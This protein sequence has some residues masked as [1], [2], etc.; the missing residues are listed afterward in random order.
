VG[1]LC[2]ARGRDALAHQLGQSMDGS[3]WLLRPDQHVMAAGGPQALAPATLAAWVSDALRPAGADGIDS[4]PEA[5]G[6]A[7]ANGDARHA[8]IPATA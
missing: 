2:D 4:Q 6:L 7:H 3:A 8:A 5:A 1:P